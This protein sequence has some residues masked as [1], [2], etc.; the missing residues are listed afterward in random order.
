MGRRQP[1]PVGSSRNDPATEWAKAVEAGKI[2]VGPHVRAACARH[3]RDLEQGSGRGLTWDRAAVRRVCRFFAEGL[4]LAGGQFEGQSFKLHPSQVFIVGSIFG[5]KRADGRRR[6]RRAYIEQGKGSGKSPLA[7]GIGMYCLVADNEQRAEV[8]AAASM[9]SQAMVLFRDAV[10]MWQQSEDLRDRLTPSGGN[11]IWNLADLQTGS[12]FRPISSEEDHSG[13]R[14]SCALCDEVHEHRNANM[15]EMLERGFKF[16]R[17]PLLIMITNSGMD[18]NSVCW[19]EHEHAVKVAAGEV[20]DDETFSFVCSLDDEDNPLENPTCWVKANP[21]LNVTIT[22]EYLAG[23][24]RQAKQLPGNSTT[25]CA[26]ISA[27]GRM[28]SRHG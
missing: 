8:Y 15:I 7:A 13:P 11:P 28:R 25:S 20:E 14:P 5:W 18:R 4:C 10:A 2:V 22:E 12:F 1:G 27:G 17:Q 3:L 16:R 6:F 9:K 26:C 23:V 24:V 19:E 21:L